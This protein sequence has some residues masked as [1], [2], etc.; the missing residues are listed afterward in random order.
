M[1]GF[2]KL[3]LKAGVSKEVSFKIAKADLSFY[4]VESKS[5]IAEPGKF[6]VLIGSSSRDICLKDR[7]KLM[8]DAK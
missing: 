3:S 7:F 4:D 6:E 1:K 2:E 8:P 5:W